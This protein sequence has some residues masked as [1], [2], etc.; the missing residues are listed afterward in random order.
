MTPNLGSPSV[1][2]VAAAGPS[3]ENPT[4]TRCA[5]ASLAAG[6]PLLGSA[7]VSG[8]VFVEI[9][10]PWPAVIEQSPR[11]PHKLG[12]ELARHRVK[13]AGIAPDPRWSR[14]DLVR[15]LA[16]RPRTEPGGVPLI[17]QELLVPPSAVADAVAGLV[18][19]PVPERSDG[20]AGRDVF[21]C[22]HGN[23]DTCCGREGVPAYAELDRLA[24]STGVR[25]WRTSHLGG[26]RF[27]PTLLD[28]PSGHCWG[29]LERG[30]LPRVLAGEITDDLL[31]R[32][33]RG[34][35]SLGPLGQVVEAELDRRHG[36]G[37]DRS[38]LWYTVVA[39]GAVYRGGTEPTRP[40]DGAEVWMGYSLRDGT[41]GLVRATLAHDGDT[42]TA[43]CGTAIGP[44]PRYRVTD[45][46][47]RAG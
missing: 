43:G 36:S 19:S 14:P 17:S 13:V 39:D 26:H 3:P 45:L 12:R 22:T 7:P 5:V 29:R 20:P 30:D 15:I 2:P 25:V 6:E 10:L 8:F 4:D 32:T 38:G 47:D 31:E 28:M 23:R 1:A 37:W 11:Y 41:H 40:L 44:V 35:V 46:S 27:A 42:N 16:Y 9:P 24:A 21:I 18:T 33:Y 34:R